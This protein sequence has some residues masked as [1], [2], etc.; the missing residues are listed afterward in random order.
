MTTYAAY[1]NKATIGNIGTNGYCCSLRLYGDFGQYHLSKGIIVSFLHKSNRRGMEKQQGYV[2]M[3]FFSAIDRLSEEEQRSMRSPVTVVLNRFAITQFEDG[4]FIFLSSADRSGV[5]KHLLLARRHANEQRWQDCFASLLA[6]LMTTL[7]VERGRIGSVLRTAEQKGVPGANDAELCVLRNSCYT[8]T[9]EVFEAKNKSHDKHGAPVQACLHTLPEAAPLIDGSTP[10]SKQYATNPHL[11][12]NVWSLAVAA[13][14]VN[15]GKKADRMVPIEQ[16]DIAQCIEPVSLETMRAI[17]TIDQHVRG[18]GN[19]AARKTFQ[20]EGCRVTNCMSPS[21]FSLGGLGYRELEKIYAEMSKIN[22]AKKAKAKANKAKAN[23]A[24]GNKAK[25]N[26]TKAKLAVRAKPKTTKPVRKQTLKSMWKKAAA[27][28]PPPEPVVEDEEEMPEDLVL[29]ES[30]DEEEMEEN[31]GEM[32]TEEKVVYNLPDIVAPRKADCI[33][34][35]K[36]A[37]TCGTLNGD[38]EGHAAGSAVFVKMGENEDNVRFAVAMSELMDVMGILPSN[39]YTSMAKI[40][41]TPGWWRKYAERVTSNHDP[42][43]KCT[44]GRKQTVVERT[45]TMLAKNGKKMNEPMVALLQT[46]FEGQLLS[47]VQKNDERLQTP[48]YAE[49]MLKIMV[50]SKLYAISDMN[51]A[52][53]MMGPDG[54]LLRVDLNSADDVVKVKHNETQLESFNRKGLMQSQK[55]AKEY[56]APV[57]DLAKRSPDLVADFMECAESVRPRREG[58]KWYTSTEVRAGVDIFAARS[59]WISLDSVFATGIDRS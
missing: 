31:R 43:Y 18:I 19:A 7:G 44:A 3:S 56:I 10:E 24:K 35:F 13:P 23:K 11:R 50:F 26:K 38:V 45:E 34:N 4:V 12:S 20:D 33:C 28:A 30:E 54:T 58:V 8:K 6:I 25:A 27:V 15:V 49:Q 47:S 1:V 48:T 53:V 51:S 22:H 9:I 52:N 16:L 59:G 29:S 42:Y 36:N 2:L 57:R 39:M 55:I 32:A 46:E 41:T 21:Q 5:V 14:I 40:K 37:S 17:G